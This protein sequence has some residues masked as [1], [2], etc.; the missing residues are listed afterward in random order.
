M[1]VI[2]LKENYKVDKTCPNGI[3]LGYFDGLHIGHQKLLKEAKE[4]MNKVN[5][6][7]SL[8]TFNPSPKQFLKNFK[9]YQNLT[10]IKEKLHLLEQLG[11]DDV[12]IIEFNKE[13]AIKNKD[14]F[15]KKY[16]LPLNPTHLFMGADYSFGNKG[17]GNADYLE[18]FITENNLGIELEVKPFE[19]YQ[20]Q[21]YSSREVINNIKSGDV[22]TAHDLLGRP[23]KISGIVIEGRK[24]G[25]TIGYPTANIEIDGNYFL[26]DKGAYIVSVNYNGKS[27]MGMCNLG[28]NPTVSNYEKMS[29]EVFILNFD[30]EIYGERLEVYFYQKLRDEMK[31]NSIEQLKEQL[32]SDEK[33][34]ENWNLEKQR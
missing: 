23:Y 16:I 31:F 25:R 6:K 22:K 30:K 9:C 10:P 34:V 18:E 26:P 5:G 7:L 33:S 28:Y 4:K 13:I 2:L 15:I 8:I 21:K 14:E 29:V 20:G 11:I 32:Q 3:V 19:K 1:N 17:E 27:Y 12:Y 24:I